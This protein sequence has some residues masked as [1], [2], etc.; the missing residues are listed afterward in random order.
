MQA[1]YEGMGQAVADPDLAYLS[2]A[3][4]GFRAKNVS[5]LWGNLWAAYR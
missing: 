5:D 2:Y 1:F 3:F 4:T